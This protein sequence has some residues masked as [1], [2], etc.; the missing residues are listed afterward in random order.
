MPER[1]STGSSGSSSSS[2]SSGGSSS[3]SSSSSYHY[4]GD[5]EPSTPE[6][7]ALGWAILIV[8]LVILGIIFITNQVKEANARR[9]NADATATTKAITIKDLA[10]M[11]A[12]LDSRIPTW[13][14]VN[15][16]QVHRVSAS[17]AGFA[18]DSNTKEVD[19]GYCEPGK[20]YVYILENSRPERTYADTEGYA[21][22]PDNTARSCHP[23]GW[24]IVS[25]D[26]AAEGW[27][28]VTISTS[29]ATF[30]ARTPSPTA[31]TS[32]Q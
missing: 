17:D 13:K 23:E 4:F 16:L 19:Y 5:N 3:H 2:S 7:Q 22:T 31:T 1:H 14:K 25:S 10:E 15:D 24:S 32:K 9:A 11:H 6:Q 21:Y 30:S 29:F 8:I 26:W 18:A 27:S 20:F 28:F 12:A